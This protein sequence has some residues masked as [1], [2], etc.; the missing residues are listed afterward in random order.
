MKYKVC[1][2][3]NENIKGV[4]KEQKEE[5]TPSGN[6]CKTFSVL[7]TKVSGNDLVPFSA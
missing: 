6:Y 3:R 5:N 7:Q 2:R 4:E 1:C